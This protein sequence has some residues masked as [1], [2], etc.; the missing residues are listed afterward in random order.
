MESWQSN[1]L[2]PE[3]RAEV[4]IP[5]AIGE[6]VLGV[7]DVQDDEVD[8]LGENDVDLLQSIAN[9]VAVA[10]QNARLY[11][12]TQQQVAREALIANIN[13]Q[14]RET[15]DMEDALKVAVRELGR[16]LGTETSVRLVTKSNGNERE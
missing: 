7:L 14:I 11:Q 15:T 4:A 2:L 13:Q 12:H 6:N 16:A 10:L 9:Q 8:G 5:I 1:P 3:T